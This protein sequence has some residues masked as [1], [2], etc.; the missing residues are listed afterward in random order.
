MATRDEVIKLMAVITLAYPNYEIKDG[1]P[2][3]Y[4]MML[5]DMDYSL[6]E[7]AAQQLIGISKFYP[8]IA[9]WRQTALD[10]KVKAANIPTAAEA[11]HEMKQSFRGFGDGSEP[12]WS[13]PL[14]AETVRLIGYYHLGHYDLANES[15][16]RTNF[17]KVYES[18][19]ARADADMRMLP[20]VRES[21]QLTSGIKMLAER[22]KIG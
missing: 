2:E 8:S 6:L 16:E 7:A 12:E 11:W 22:M 5:Q 4:Y 15:Y 19:A 17:F 14:I 21:L 3:L 20:S 9:E 10:L 18:L 13:H 1:Q